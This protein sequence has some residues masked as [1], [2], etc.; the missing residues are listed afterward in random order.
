M[1]GDQDW[2]R[3]HEWHYAASLKGWSNNNLGFQWLRNVFDPQTRLPD[4]QR[5]LLILNGHGSHLSAW[6]CCYSHNHDIDLLLPPHTS[7]VLQPLDVGV[8]KELKKVI[9][10]A[11]EDRWRL[12][13]ISDRLSKR[14]FII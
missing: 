2:R 6:F 14:D 8:F 11:A 9:C 12:L 5:R 10:Q 7:N 3:T 4:R 1:L 13:A